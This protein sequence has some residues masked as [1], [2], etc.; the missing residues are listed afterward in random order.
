MKNVLF[1]HRVHLTFSKH[2]C[3]EFIMVYIW[4]F[5]VSQKRNIMKPSDVQLSSLCLEDHPATSSWMV[6]WASWRIFIV[7]SLRYSPETTEASLEN[8]GS[9]TLKFYFEGLLN[10]KRWNVLWAVVTR[11]VSTW[12]KIPISCI[13]RSLLISQLQFLTWYRFFKCSIIC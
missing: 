6:S 1:P 11:H 8:I 12:A 13:L 10:V 4:M 9:E 5:S 2:L 7:K 3:K